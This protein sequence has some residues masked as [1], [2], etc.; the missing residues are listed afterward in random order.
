MRLDD[1]ISPKEAAMELGLRYGQV[2]RLIKSKKLPA[3]KVG[4]GWLVPKTAV[5]KEKAKKHE[6]HP[7]SA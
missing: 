6:G 3:E 7:I 4:W 1:Y 5:A 2:M